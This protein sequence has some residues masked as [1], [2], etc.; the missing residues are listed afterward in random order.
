MKLFKLFITTVFITTITHLSFCQDNNLIR[1]TKT[2][3][4]GPKFINFGSINGEKK[5]VKLV[6]KN[7]RPNT[8][9]ICD[10]KTPKGFVVSINNQILQPKSQTLLFIG[11]DPKLISDTLVNGKIIIE[12]NLIIPI[13]INVKA[14][15]KKN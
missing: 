7:E 3:I 14:R 6:V 2:Q 10:I 8:V 5:F 1:I 13:T 11:L 15:I 9:N 12:T 4:I